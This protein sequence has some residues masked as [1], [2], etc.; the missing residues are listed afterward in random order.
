MLSGCWLRRSVPPFAERRWPRL[1]KPPDLVL[2]CWLYAYRY[3]YLM[4]VSL[5]CW[6]AGE[7]ASGILQQIARLDEELRAVG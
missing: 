7:A 1:A 4:D 2:V 5:A 6:K 3:I